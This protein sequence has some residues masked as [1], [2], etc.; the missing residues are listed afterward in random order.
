MKDN[1]SIMCQ[2]TQ[3]EF[4]EK[5]YPPNQTDPL[6]HVILRSLI[7][8][9]STSSHAVVNTDDDIVNSPSACRNLLHRP[10]EGYFWGFACKKNINLFFGQSLQNLFDFKLDRQLLRPGMQ[11]DLDLSKC[12]GQLVFWYG[13]FCYR[14][15]E[16]SYHDD[17]GCSW[18]FTWIEPAQ[19]G[20][21]SG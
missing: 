17:G 3:S 16:K 2:S 14:N 13:C 15:T 19:C 12:Q 21:T 10:R 7:F 4:S 8:K 5:G 9:V 20:T 6:V 11:N 18:K 1:R